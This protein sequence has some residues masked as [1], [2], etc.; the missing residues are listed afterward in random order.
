[1]VL[2][3]SEHKKAEPVQQGG[4]KNNNILLEHSNLPGEDDKQRE[5]QTFNI[6]L[7]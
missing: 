5:R 2:K 1:M 6:L 4:Q 7:V 3:Q